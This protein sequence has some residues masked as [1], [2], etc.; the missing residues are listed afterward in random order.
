MMFPK[1]VRKVIAASAI[2][3][4]DGAPNEFWNGFKNATVEMM[5]EELRA[6]HARFNPDPGYINEMFRR[7]AKRMSGFKDWSAKDL[8]KIEVPTLIL[9][10]DQDMMSVEQEVKLFR[11][12][13]GAR[14]MILPA[15]H[16]SYLK[17]A[18]LV[19][20]IDAFLA[21]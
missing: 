14:L 11:L 15:S 18:A 12:V 9:A 3:R 6:A 20:F 19:P 4:R 7:D 1:K 5:P 13:P 2:Y 21:Q 10:G 17:D 16:G 8:R